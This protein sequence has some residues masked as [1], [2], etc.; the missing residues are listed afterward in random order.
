MKLVV[1]GA[2]GFIGSNLIEDLIERGEHEVLGVDIA[3]NKLAGIEGSGFEFVQADITT[4]YEL[5]DELVAAS[6]AVVDLVAYANPSIYVESPL[7]VVQL[8]FFDNLRIAEFC[9]KHG[10]RLIQY[11]TSEVYGKNPQRA[12]F[13]E[14]ES[15][16]I[17]GPVTK[18]RWIYA[19]S[20]QLLERMLHGY[21]LR[22]DLNYTIVR[23]FNFVGPRFDYLVEAGARGGPRVFAHYMSALLTGG[24]MYLVDG[25]QQRRSFT[26][27]K[28]ANEAFSVLLGNPAAHNQIFNVG[29]PATDTSIRDLALLMRQIYA[30]LTGETPHNELVEISGEE[31]YGVGYEDTDRVP[32][33]ISKL[34]ALGWEPRRGLRETFKDAI[35]YNL[36]PTNRSTLG[37]VK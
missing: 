28:D 17:L 16:L 23:P 24:P 8:N 21:G 19:A 26:H 12:T 22:G 29:N 15:D 31:F 1:L 36:D 35:E 30:D 34:E 14:A 7:E 27:I 32:P 37:G 13:S 33:D 9:I 4:S 2:G 10:K 5:I 18:Q 25:G 11:S 6:D 20:K 3:S